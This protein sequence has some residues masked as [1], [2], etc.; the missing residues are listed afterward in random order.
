MIKTYREVLRDIQPGEI[1]D[2]KKDCNL[3]SI[4][5]KNNV[6]R[7]NYECHVDSYTMN[8]D[9]QFELRKEKVEFED[10]IKA[11]KENKI[12]QSL[13][14]EYYFKIDKN[15][16]VFTKS[17]TGKWYRVSTCFDD[18]EIFGKWHIYDEGEI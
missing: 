16:N 2:C 4:S 8:D 3:K 10:A 1:W 11:L 9:V 12:I 13:K 17:E 15:N 7:I 5:Y 18:N 6:I 14:T